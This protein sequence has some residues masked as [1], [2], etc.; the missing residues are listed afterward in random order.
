MQEN[1][2]KQKLDAIVP[3]FYETNE[4]AKASKKESES[5]KEEIKSIFEELNIK[6]YQFENIK[7]SVQ[8]IEKSSLIE[9]L[10]ID[11]LKQH[12]LQHLIRTKEYI[13][14]ADI[15]MAAS[16]GQINVVDLEPFTSTKTEKRITVRKGK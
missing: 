3:K 9:P 1:E 11:Y 8:E 4:I 5:Y 7:V 16:N 14:E 15:L 13:E 2:F 6:E 10:V 12:N